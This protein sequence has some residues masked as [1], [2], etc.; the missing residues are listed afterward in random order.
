MT[1][2]LVAVAWAF[3]PIIIN[4]NNKKKPTTTPIYSTLYLLE[5]VSL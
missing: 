5:C 1:N 2:K 3:M 4:N